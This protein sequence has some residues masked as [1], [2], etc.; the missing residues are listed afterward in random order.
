MAQWQWYILVNRATQTWAP[1]SVLIPC[2]GSIYQI[3]LWCVKSSLSKRW[4]VIPVKE[5][6]I[7]RFLQKLELSIFFY[8]GRN[9]E[10]PS[11]IGFHI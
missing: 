3:V 4:M 2:R 9:N 7:E 5:I 6:L 11:V 8:T 10:E 1:D